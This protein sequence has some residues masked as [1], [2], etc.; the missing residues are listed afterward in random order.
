MAP[1]M[2]KLFASR[3][4]L[5]ITLQL[6]QSDAARAPP[7]VSQLL[8]VN[9]QPELAAKVMAG[10]KTVTRRLVSD[11]PR[12]PWYDGGL[13]AEGRPHLRRLPRAQQA[14]ARPRAHHRHA[15]RADRLP[16]RREAVREGFADAA[17]FERAFV[18][19]NGGTYD[20][21][22]LVWRVEFAVVPA[23]DLPLWERAA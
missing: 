23:E 18:A 1:I 5:E 15:P 9:F 17:E 11:N 6:L 20:P 16:Q 10:E 14:P 8:G 19:I 21:S 3:T 13:Q 12:S 2:T 4:A 7:C 22:A